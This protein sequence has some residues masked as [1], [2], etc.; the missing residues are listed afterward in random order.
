M[1]IPFANVSMQSVYVN[2]QVRLPQRLTEEQAEVISEMLVLNALSPK[3]WR[4]ELSAKLCLK[5]I[6]KH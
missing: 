4:F 2:L 3:C 6:V 1:C 5:N